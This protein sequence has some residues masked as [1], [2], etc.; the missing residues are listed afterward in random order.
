MY[1]YLSIFLWDAP[2]AY[3]EQRIR[4]G[5]EQVTKKSK[6]RGFNEDR[7]HDSVGREFINVRTMYELWLQF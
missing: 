4:F 1:L 5:L 6:G 2:K 3:Y 7:R